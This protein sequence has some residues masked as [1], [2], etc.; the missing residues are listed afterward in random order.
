MPYM[1][2]ENLLVG[3]L[4][5][6]VPIEDTEE[7]RLDDSSAGYLL[8]FNKDGESELLAAIWYTHDR[9][10]YKRSGD[11]WTLIFQENWRDNYAEDIIKA[12]INN[13]GLPEF[14]CIEILD[15]YVSENLHWGETGDEKMSGGI[16]RLSCDTIEDL[17][18]SWS[19]LPHGVMDDMVNLWLYKENEN[20]YTCVLRDGKNGA[21]GLS[22]LRFDSSIRT[23]VKSY[24]IRAETVF[25]AI[26]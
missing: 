26:P 3:E 21:Y 16:W 6:F 13:D 4:R 1:V 19:L 9:A 7:G 8:D 22:I 12:D 11:G 2:S 10:A 14:L 25:T 20:V 15:P 17:S 24:G 23:V 18:R 5:Q